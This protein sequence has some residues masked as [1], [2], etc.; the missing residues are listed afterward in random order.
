M[1][2][3]APIRALLSAT[4]CAV[5]V[6]AAGAAPAQA[7]SLTVC[8]GSC[9][10]SSIQAAV[11]AASPGDAIVVRAGT[12][13]E[14]VNVDRRLELRGP[15]A[16]VDARERAGGTGREA[17]LAP[18]SGVDSAGFLL[19]ADNITVDG[20]RIQNSPEPGIVT[21]REHAG[22]RIENNVIT[23]N[24]V[25]IRLNGA[26]AATTRT[27][28][29][30][31]RIDNNN[32][33]GDSSGI[34]SDLGISNVEI[35][36]NLLAG[37]R[38]SGIR[39]AGLGDEAS[40]S[41]GIDLIGNRLSDDAGIFIQ[42]ARSVNVLDNDSIKPGR[43]SFNGLHLAG[44][45]NG[46][47]VRA[48]R[49]IAHRKRQVPERADDVAF[50]DVGVLISNRSGLGPNGG[51]QVIGNTLTD[52][53]R[54]VST[55][56]DPST[57]ADDEAY[58]GELKVEFNR[59]VRNSRGVNND[60]PDASELVDADNNWWGCN[61]GPNDDLNRCE[62]V[63][64]NVNFDP[65]LTLE[66]E[67]GDELLRTRGRAT[68]I[69]AAVIEN[70]AGDTPTSFF[71]DRTTIGFSATKGNIRKRARTLNGVARTVFS[72]TARRGKAK[73]SARLDNE[74]KRTRIEIERRGG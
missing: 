4:A 24:R 50:K 65:W 37:H 57:G 29:R 32:R 23:S 62:N 31:N 64:V 72:T 33:G 42:N 63:S 21:R 54:G 51:V 11:N 5:A 1:T 52:A 53:R 19:A 49:F 45:V 15:Q 35:A 34:A 55:S 25:G 60:D 28:V 44:N 14:R 74:R 3:K 40:L 12:Y 22:H 43:V 66:L 2:I 26:P 7:A 41:E 8:R 18:G 13:N 58:A 73:I 68:E 10:F 47:L 17:V 59:I 48:N 61:Q 36:D 16:N 6:A 9:D 27:T 56:S 71:P 69:V 46:A 38:Q 39:I 67:A 30:R 20:F 70:S